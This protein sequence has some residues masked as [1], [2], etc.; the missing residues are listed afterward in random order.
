MRAGSSPV[1]RTKKLQVFGLGVLLS[2]AFALIFLDKYRCK[3]AIYV[4]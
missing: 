3:T 4:V 2:F 1:I